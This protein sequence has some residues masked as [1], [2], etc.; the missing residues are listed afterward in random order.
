MDSLLGLPALR[1]FL[2]ALREL[3]VARSAA[4]SGRAR[5]GGRCDW[6]VGSVGGCCWLGLYLTRL[7][8]GGCRAVECACG[9]GTLDSAGSRFGAVGVGG[10]AD[11]GVEL[12]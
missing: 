10:A 2:C 11:A 3:C 8:G 9:E 4:F 12:C 6:L 5:G 1:S 7:G